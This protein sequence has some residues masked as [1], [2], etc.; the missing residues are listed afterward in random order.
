M[1][2]RFEKNTPPY[3]L[4]LTHHHLL[5]SRRAFLEMMENLKKKGWSGYIKVTKNKT[6]KMRRLFK[7]FIINFL[8]LAVVRRGRSSIHPVED[9]YDA[10]NE[11]ETWREVTSEK[12]E[13]RVMTY[14]IR[15]GQ[16]EFNVLGKVETVISS[17]QAFIGK[18]VAMRDRTL[19]VQ[20]VADALMLFRCLY[21][22][23]NL[24]EDDLPKCQGLKRDEKVP[25]GFTP[26]CGRTRL[27][28]YALHS[29][30]CHDVGDLER[31]IEFGGETKTAA[32][33]IV[34]NHRNLVS[35]LRRALDTYSCSVGLLKKSG[36][37]T[38]EIDNDMQEFSLTRGGDAASLLT[39]VGHSDG[40]H[41]D[42][43]EEIVEKISASVDLLSHTGDCSTVAA[44]KKEQC[45]TIKRFCEIAKREDEPNHQLYR[46]MEAVKA[47]LTQGYR[48]AITRTSKVSGFPA[49]IQ[50]NQ[51]NDRRQWKDNAKDSMTRI[52][53]KLSESGN[54]NVATLSGHSNFWLKTV[55]AFDSP[56]PTSCSEPTRKQKLLK[57][58]S[59]LVPGLGSGNCALGIKCKD[60]FSKK[61][62]NGGVLMIE[63]VQENDE[64]SIAECDLV[65]GHF[66]HHHR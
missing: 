52:L 17:A 27:I 14:M 9:S 59:S 5:V 44:E 15:H 1:Y 41:D 56:D 31:E 51:R 66:Q 63:W 12:R 64:W 40:D 33:W 53:N 24:K 47:Y 54:H 57:S 58:V 23:L 55:Q 46:C 62:G 25:L 49:N 39:D 11:G 38:L 4:L 65:F 19:T 50:D 35:N 18:N 3:L 42:Y 7:F 10:D 28:R 21:S 29:M 16:S 37:E 43:I 34:D 20:G 22:A 8:L 45:E 2:Y 36:E 26:E 6:T 30:E 48:G 60:A 61:I 13:K 32:Q